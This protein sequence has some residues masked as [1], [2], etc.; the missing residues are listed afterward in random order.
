MP[1]V[2]YDLLFFDAS[3]E[4]GEF[5][6]GSDIVGPLPP[7]TVILKG[8]YL[9]P[10]EIDAGRLETARNQLRTANA[11]L[12]RPVTSSDGPPFRSALIYRT[13]GM[14][15][16]SRVTD[17]RLAHAFAPRGE[18]VYAYL[19]QAVRVNGSGF[20]WENDATRGRAGFFL[21]GV[22]GTSA[23][24][25]L[26][27]LESDAQG[28]GLLTLAPVRLPHALAMPD[29]GGIADPHL[30][31]HLRAHFEGFQRAVATNAH[32]DVVDRAYNV[33]EG[34]VGHFLAQ[35][36][37]SVPATLH[38]RVVEARKLLADKERRE[39][40]PLTVYGLALAEKIRHLHR[41]GHADQ[42]VERRRTIR[43]E[44]GM[45]VATDLSELLLEAGLAEY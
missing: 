37:Q 43:P 2:G 8:V 10:D 4:F 16:V 19:Y 28:R 22:S 40:F 13:A 35:A 5:I 31:E 1:A 45:A 29:F 11:Y 24:W 42:A 21:T 12:L 44:V 25:R 32:L 14:S 39:A 36:G 9:P 26:A 15:E 27:R 23:L 7:E 33:A 6:S 30:R 18:K 17:Q 38:G 20:D 3:G 41:H 34:V